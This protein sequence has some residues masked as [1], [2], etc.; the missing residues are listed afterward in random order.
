MNPLI[1][2]PTSAISWP[3]WLKG[4]KIG[5]ALVEKDYRVTHT[6]WSLLDQGFELWFKGGT[7]LSKSFQ[8]IER[9]SEDLNVKIEPGRVAKLEPITNWK[10]AKP[11]RRARYFNQIAS[12]CRISN[13]RVENDHPPEAG[14][15]RVLYE[16]RH[17][18]LL[19]P[20]MKPFVLLEIGDARVT[21]Y[22]FCDLTSFVHEHLEAEGQLGEFVDNRPTATHQGTDAPQFGVVCK[23]PLCI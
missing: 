16:G 19:A 8:L 4:E 14:L 11:A 15:L 17:A 12:L 3:S 20:P 22:V 10:N 5:I 7:S 9:F 13:A 23:G 18:D 21:P 6:L 2:I 1:K